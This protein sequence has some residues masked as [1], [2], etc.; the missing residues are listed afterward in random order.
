MNLTTTLGLCAL[1]LIGI[2]AAPVATAAAV[3]APDGS[4]TACR[5]GETITECAARALHEFCATFVRNCPL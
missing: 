3:T 5:E 2:V 4:A 1:L